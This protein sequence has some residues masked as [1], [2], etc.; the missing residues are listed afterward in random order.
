MAYEV[1]DI[2]KELT[3]ALINRVN[4]PSSADKL[5]PAKWVGDAYKIIYKAVAKPSEPKEED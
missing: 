4:L 3:V 2:A 1:G 5:Y